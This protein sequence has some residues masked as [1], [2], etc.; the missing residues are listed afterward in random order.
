MRTAIFQNKA[1]KTVTFQEVVDFLKNGVKV[2]FLKVT[3]IVEYT[4][5]NIQGLKEKFEESGNI[6]VI[7][8]DKQ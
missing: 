3:E 8:V 6:L 2:A 1:E 7:L 4:N 5:P